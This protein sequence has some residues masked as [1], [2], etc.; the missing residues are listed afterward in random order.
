M[1]EL[2]ILLELIMAS[3]WDIRYRALP[4]RFLGIITIVN[5]VLIATCTQMAWEEALIG[6]GLGVIL[7]ILGRVTREA[8]GYGDG[9]LFIIVG[10]VIGI[11]W[12]WWVFLITMGFLFLSSLFLWLLKKVNRKYALPLVPFM[13]ISHVV[14]WIVS[15]VRL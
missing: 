5:F 9:I 10:M 4:R 12:I 14:Y 11:R 13:T 7:L 6:G 3:I 1:V 15:Y 2:V 8:I